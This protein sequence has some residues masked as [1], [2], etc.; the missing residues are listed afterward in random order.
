MAPAEPKLERLRTLIRSMGSA[1]VAFSGG[2]D[3]TLVAKIAKDELGGHALLV[4]VDSPL[5]PRNELKDARV[6]ART[7]GLRHIVVRMDPLRDPSFSGNPPDRC[8]TCKLATFKEV[9]RIADDRSLRHVLRR[10]QLGRRAGVQ[11]GVEGEGGAGCQESTG[12]GLDW[13][14]KIS[15]GYPRGFACRRTRRPRARAWPRGCLTETR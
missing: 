2:S 8:Y 1:A 13:A 4:T 10:L 6:L 14:R 12:G 9:R 11:A 5:Y 3:S 15:S 7:I